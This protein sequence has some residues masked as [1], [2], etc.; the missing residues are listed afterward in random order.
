MGG[1]ALSET[2]VFGARAG[3][4]AAEHAKD[5]T[6][7]EADRE[8]VD[9]EFQRVHT[10]FKDQGVHP[11]VIRERLGS[12]M[13]AN[14]GVIRNREGMERALRQIEDL[15]GQTEDIRAP[16]FKRFNRLW[17]EALEVASM[18]DVAEMVVRSALFREE[19]RGA[20]YREEYPETRKE[21]LKH[22]CVREQDSKMDLT[23]RPV[24]ITK[25]KCGH[26]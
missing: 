24:V 26:D 7:F 1:N 8:F 10:F 17:I 9:T 21:W 3:R 5:S 11:W 19:S 25:L 12:L 15:K 2:L 6:F 18:F 13:C 16:K 20:H 14:L 23:T 4:F 22:T